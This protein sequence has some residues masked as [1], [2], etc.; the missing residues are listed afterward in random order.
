MI[1]TLPRRR[2]IRRLTPA[3]QVALGLAL[4]TLAGGVARLT[5]GV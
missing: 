4:L 5:L 2:R 3:G 1:Q